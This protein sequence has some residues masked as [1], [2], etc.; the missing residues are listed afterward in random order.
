[1]VEKILTS[2]H[3][4]IRHLIFLLCFASVAISWWESATADCKYVDDS[5]NKRPLTDTSSPEEKKA[6]FQNL[7]PHNICV[8]VS[9]VDKEV[10]EY[11]QWIK[12]WKKKTLVEAVYDVGNTLCRTDFCDIEKETFYSKFVTAC[13]TAYNDAL[14]KTFQPAVALDETKWLIGTESCEKELIELKLR[15]YKDA[16]MEE[17]ARN[18]KDIIE[19]SSDEYLAKAHEVFDTVAD[20]FNNFLLK[21]GAIA[22]SFEAFTGRA[23]V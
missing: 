18:Q 13:E 1:M 12:D 2:T 16:A 19:W 3:M 8:E 21:F 11:I 23:F 14:E 7:Y 15:A 4:K 20:K 10:E 9:K 22:R 6:A 5:S 17:V